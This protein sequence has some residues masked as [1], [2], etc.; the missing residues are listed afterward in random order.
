MP[1]PYILVADDDPSILYLVADILRDEGYAV[2]L[3]RNGGEALDV[4]GRRDEPALVILDMRMPV[5]DG[6]EFAA[7][8]RARQLTP[9]ILVMTA[10]SNAREW[11]AEIEAVGYLAKPFDLDDF[12]REVSRLAPPPHTTGSDGRSLF[13]LGPSVSLLA[14]VRRALGAG[15]ASRAVRSA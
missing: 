4:I 11:A 2:E 15:G 8:L 1:A 13:A 7:M 10:A 9:P 14:A 5:V 6:W 3:A 12:L